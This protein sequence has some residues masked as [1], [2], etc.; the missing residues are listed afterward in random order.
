MTPWGRLVPMDTGAVNCTWYSQALQPSSM[1]AWRS[2]AAP[3]AALRKRSSAAQISGNR[4]ATARMA[5]LCSVSVPPSAEPSHLGH[6]A[7][8]L[9]EAGH[10]RQPL[11]GRQLGEIALEA[12]EE[13]RERA[14]SAPTT[15][16]RPSRSTSVSS[17]SVSAASYRRGNTGSPAAERR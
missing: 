14:S 5:Q 15:A 9:E 7:V 4:S 2:T 17:T 13:R 8:L 3:R 11:L 10:R 1:W 16:S 12:P 6:E